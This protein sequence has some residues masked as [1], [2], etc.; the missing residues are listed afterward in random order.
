MHFPIVYLFFDYNINV[1]NNHIV[2]KE[3]SQFLHLFFFVFLLLIVV[4]YLIQVVKIKAI[5]H[6]LQYGN[7]KI[8]SFFWGFRSNE[9]FIYF[10]QKNDN[11]TNDSSSYYSG[12]FAKIETHMRVDTPWKNASFSLGDLAKSVN[13]NSM[14]VSVAINKMADNNFKVYINEFR[15]KAIINEIMQKKSNNEIIILKD[16]YLNNG[17]NHQATF[18]K[19]FKAYYGKTPQEYINSI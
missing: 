19:V 4:Y 15:L 8:D 6:F 16:V 18:N 3:L 10:K 2:Q 13:S 14:Y 7:V 5:I 1:T 11:E 17:F 12:L 9:E